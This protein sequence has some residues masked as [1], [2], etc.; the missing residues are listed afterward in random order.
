MLVFEAL[1]S[2]CPFIKR[3]RASA[4]IGLRSPLAFNW[5]DVPVIREDLVDCDLIKLKQEICEGHPPWTIWLLCSRCILNIFFH[6]LVF[7]PVISFL[8]ERTCPHTF[9]SPRISYSHQLQIIF[10]VISHVNDCVVMIFQYA[11]LSLLS[12]FESS[13]FHTIDC[14]KE[15]FLLKIAIDDLPKSY[16]I[17]F[18]SF[19]L[20]LHLFWE[21]SC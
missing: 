14:W 8:A 19:S 20:K 3:N 15:E 17:F 10:W 6:C 11:L 4:S 5:V 2:L 16:W 21:S 12:I 18:I 9:V 1:L 7:L 13:F